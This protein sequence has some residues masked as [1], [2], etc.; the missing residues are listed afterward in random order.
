MRRAYASSE[1]NYWAE[2]K[3]SVALATKETT[4]TRTR[5]FIATA[6]IV[7][8]SSMAHAQASGPVI[9]S[10]PWGCRD[11]GF[12]NGTYHHGLASN[13][14]SLHLTDTALR[15]GE[16]IVDLPKQSIDLETLKLKRGR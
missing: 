14:G 10:G 3:T 12:S 4:M 1:H 8:A 9:V 6:F 16:A 7:A 11:C 15:S 2:A 13:I 5:I